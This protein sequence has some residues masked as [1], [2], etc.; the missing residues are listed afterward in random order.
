MRGALKTVV[1]L[2]IL[3]Y[4]PRGLVAVIVK[5]TPG[6]NYARDDP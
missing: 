6:A 3:E 5:K 2:N 1:H 4:L